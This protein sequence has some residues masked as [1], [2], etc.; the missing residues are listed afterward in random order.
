MKTSGAFNENSR[1]D[2]QFEKQMVIDLSDFYELDKK[3]E[4]K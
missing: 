1:F 2:L 4:D 3:V